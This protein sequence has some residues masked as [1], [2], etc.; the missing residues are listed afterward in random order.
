MFLFIEYM[1]AVYI[2]YAYINTNTKKN[3]LFVFI[4]YIYV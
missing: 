2:Y 3:M 4:K 1:C